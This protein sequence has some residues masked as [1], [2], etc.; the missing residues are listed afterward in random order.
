MN[1]DDLTYIKNEEDLVYLHTK[2]FPVNIRLLKS[3]II[4]KQLIL[5]CCKMI[6]DY[7]LTTLEGYSKPFGMSG[8]NLAIPFNIIG[9]VMNR[10][11]D[12][13]FVDILLNPE[14]IRTGKYKIPTKSNCGSIRLESSINISRWQYITV[15]WYDLSGTIHVRQFSPQQGS[16]TIQHEIDHNNGILI[17]DRK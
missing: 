13:E 16:F 17:T 7:A 1:I 6:S 10:G 3:S 12:N 8:A 5:Q 14:I 4:Y 9:I 11:K 2:L 15:K